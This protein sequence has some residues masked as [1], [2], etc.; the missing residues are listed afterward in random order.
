MNPRIEIT[1][2]TIAAIMP[3]PYFVDIQLGADG[4]AEDEVIAW[5]LDKVGNVVGL[6][7]RLVEL[8][9]VTIGGEGD[10]G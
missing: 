3:F 9:E 1:P 7:R 5:T 8:D 6:A 2:K 4:G 10:D